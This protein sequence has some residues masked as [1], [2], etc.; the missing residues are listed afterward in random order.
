MLAG[1]ILVYTFA[2]ADGFQTIWRYFAWANQLLA[3]VTLWAIT[4]YLAINKKVYAVT[5]IPALFMTMVCSTFILI[6]DSGFN[7]SHT[8]A[9]LLGGLITLAACIGFLVWKMKKNKQAKPVDMTK[10]NATKVPEK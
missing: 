3:M 2:D 8:V 5:L 9:Y 7:L 6:S 4:V 10:D 1:A